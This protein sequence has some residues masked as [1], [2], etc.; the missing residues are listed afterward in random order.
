MTMEMRMGL[1]SMKSKLAADGIEYILALFV[2]IN[3]AAKVKQVPVGCFED[4]V[5]DGA[6][7]AGAAVWGM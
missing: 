4:I 1:E 5:K 7:F 6:G 2:D 3:G